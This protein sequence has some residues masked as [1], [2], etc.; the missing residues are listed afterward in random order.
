MV[1]KFN[2]SPAHRW[3]VLIGGIYAAGE[4]GAYVEWV[5][6]LKR[7]NIIRLLD[8]SFSGKSIF[9]GEKIIE[10]LNGMIGD[11]NIENL[12]IGFTAVATDINE[13]KEI[14]LT[15]GSLFEAIRAS[16]AV[17]TIFSPVK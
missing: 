10:V 7:R 14:W 8:L 3:G 1:L 6:A 2:I 9:K 4:L 13:Q 12:S 15:Q 5:S 16:I 11:R 17:P